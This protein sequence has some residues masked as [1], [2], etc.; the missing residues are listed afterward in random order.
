[1]LDPTGKIVRASRSGSVKSVDVKRGDHI[2]EGTTIVTVLCWDENDGGL[3]E[4][5]LES[6]EAG[7]VSRVLVRDD[8]AVQEGQAIVELE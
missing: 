7:T 4:V 8:A 3:R 5:D 2:D 1:M 6:D